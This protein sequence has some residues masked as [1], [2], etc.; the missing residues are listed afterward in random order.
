MTFGQPHHIA[1]V[2]ETPEV[3]QGDVTASKRFAL[4]IQS[5][6]GMLWTLGTDTYGLRSYLDLAHMFTS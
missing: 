3:K 6:V 5:L 1:V 4:Q 2:L